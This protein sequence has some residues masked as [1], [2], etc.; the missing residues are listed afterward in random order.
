VTLQLRAIG[1]FVFGILYPEALP[2]AVDV[3]SILCGM[4]HATFPAKGLRGNGPR[5]SFGPLTLPIGIRQNVHSFKE[6]SWD[7]TAL[8]RSCCVKSAV[9]RTARKRR[10]HGNTTVVPTFAACSLIPS[11]DRRAAP[12]GAPQSSGHCAFESDT[13]PRRRPV[14]P[15]WPTKLTTPLPS[16]LH[17]STATSA[18]PTSLL[19]SRGNAPRKHSR[20]HRASSS[21]VTETRPPKSYSAAYPT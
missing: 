2:S 1:V 14:A 3:G 4:P 16:P 20:S 21:G 5:L 12:A 7:R 19:G 15:W 17:R 11:A 9:S 8:T 18:A 6:N 10:P 13:Y